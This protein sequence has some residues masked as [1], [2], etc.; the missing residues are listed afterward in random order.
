[1]A[2]CL[3]HRLCPIPKSVVIHWSLAAAWML[4][5]TLPAAEKPVLDR[6]FPSGARLGSTV[7]VSVSGKLGGPPIEFWSDLGQLTAVVSENSDKVT[8]TVPPDAA[9]G[10]HW[11]RF[12]NS[13]GATAIRPFVVANSAEHLEVE[14]NNRISESSA[15][16]ETPC[17][18]N[19][20]LEKAGD[21]DIFSIRATAGQTL[22]ASVLA[23]RTLTSPMDSVLQLLDEHGNVLIQ[24]DD[25]QGVDPLIAYTVKAD[26]IYRFRL[27]AFPSDPNSSIQFAGAPSY[28]YRITIGSGSVAD[29]VE[30]LAVQSGTNSEVFLR[31]WNLPS[32]GLRVHLANVPAAGEVTAAAQG[33]ATLN[34]SSMLV[35]SE[36]PLP[37]HVQVVDQP[38]FLENS[39]L[40]EPIPELQCP[41]SVSGSISMNAEKDV[42]RFRAE[43]G[44]SLIVHLD[45]R[46]L[47]SLLDPAL[48]IRTSADAVLT[49][50][51]DISGTNLDASTHVKVP[52]DGLVQVEIR[53]RFAHG[54]ERYYYLLTVVPSNPKVRLTVAETDLVGAADK[55]AELSVSVER[56]WGF[57]RVLE[58]AMDGLPAGLQLEPVRSEK[59]GDSSKTVKLRIT[60]SLE[61]DFSGPLRIFARDV[62]SGATFP[63]V[64][65]PASLPDAGDRI[66]TVWL[67]WAKTAK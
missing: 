38:V 5:V 35:P 39:A 50:A 58:L 53:D 3:M 49:E 22:V 24:N 13:A 61:Q 6:L 31:G 30:P 9:L 29:H 45:A 2:A 64:C 41:R 32:E 28:V 12:W 1:M 51:D 18:V 63:V 34:I 26:G 46:R 27:F 37:V 23:Y 25:D 17:I 66:Q 54:G 4:T 21:V 14:P 65:S 47:G 16:L 36:S 56:T 33:P 59:E 57:D 42:W 11:V 10:T 48:T 43:P 60:G 44:I 19:G 62:E 40:S 67:S 20:V 7:E 8:I 15:V 52:D 55:P